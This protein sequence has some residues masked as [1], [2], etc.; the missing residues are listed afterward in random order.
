MG[1]DLLGRR[2][3]SRVPGAAAR[4]M[5]T[6]GRLM[7][8]DDVDRDADGA[9]L[10]GE[11]PGHGLA[12]PPGGVGGETCSRGRS[13]TSRPPGCR[14]RLPSWTRSSMVSPRPTYRLATD[15]TSR[16]F[17]SIRRLLGDPAHDDEPV[18]VEREPAVQVR[19]VDAV[20][21][22]RTGRPCTPGEVDLLGGGEQR[23]P[24]DLPQVL[25][26][27]VEEGP[28]L[29]VRVGGGGSSEVTA[30][31]PGWRPRQ[32]P[33]APLAPRIRRARRGPQ[34]PR[35]PRA[36]RARAREVRFWSSCGGSRPCRPGGAR[37]GASAA[38]SARQDA[39]R[40]VRLR[41]RRCRRSVWVEG[42]GAPARWAT[43]RMDAAGW[44]SAAVLRGRSRLAC[45]RPPR[46]RWSGPRGSG[47]PGPRSGDSGTAPECGVRHI[48]A[49]RGVRALFE[50]G[51]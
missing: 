6:T 25:A 41:R 27:Q 46:T 20:S 40:R 38:A 23:D 12:D 28:P 22:R 15:T 10:V 11:R 51:R 4:W 50:S 36:Q 2:A 17:A 49:T 21:P 24:A 7:I 48:V 29:S 9:R 42:P 34:G 39:G 26:E 19:G 14:P 32:G 47:G 33:R 35:G 8:F 44:G 43:S 37:H 5:W 13:R 18:E 1:G 45:R 31:G 30:S 16:R 3:R